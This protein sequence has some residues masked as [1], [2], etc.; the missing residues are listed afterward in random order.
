MFKRHYYAQIEEGGLVVA[1][2]DLSAEVN[3]P[4]LI[5]IASMDACL[6]GDTYADGVFVTPPEPTAEEGV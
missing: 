2:S 5:A 6:L 3:K 1:I 4:E